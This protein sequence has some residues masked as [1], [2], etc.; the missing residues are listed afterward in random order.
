MRA[1]PRR[2]RFAFAR[3]AAAGLR[4]LVRRRPLFK[5]QQRFG[6]DTDRE[7]SLHHVLKAMTL[8]GA[9]F[10]PPL[11]LVNVE[12]LD[13]ELR[14]G[15]GIFFAATH[16]VFMPLVFRHLWDRGIT[17]YVVAATPVAI[18]GTRAAVHPV[19]PSRESLLQVRRLLRGGEVV[20]AMLDTLEKVDDGR[21]VQFE[22]HAGRIRIRDTLL[23]LSRRCDAA[24]F[25]VAARINDAGGISVLLQKAGADP[26][27]EFVAFVQTHARR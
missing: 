18:L 1:V 25:F 10:D 16:Q 7:L 21:T 17:P 3:V 8:A 22:T 27:A 23:R 20:S 2:Y 14:A 26:V 5:E 6:M 13:E 15:R 4:P 12:Q 19:A 24:I 9:V 11:T